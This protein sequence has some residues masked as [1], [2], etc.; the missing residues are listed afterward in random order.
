MTDKV[1]IPN[2][3]EVSHEEVANMNPVDI[4]ELDVFVHS[5]AMEELNNSVHLTKLLLAEPFNKV[6]VYYAPIAMGRVNMLKVSLDFN[7]PAVFLSNMT[8]QDMLSKC[9]RWKAY[10]IETTNA[11]ITRKRNELNKLPEL[12][13]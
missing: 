9:T 8:V 4:A 6:N 1:K 3:G 10:P 12:H 5:S 2:Y 11:D 13:S 7:E